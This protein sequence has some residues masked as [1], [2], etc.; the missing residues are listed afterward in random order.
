M[1]IKNKF[2]IERIIET[3]PV[4]DSVSIYKEDIY[5]DG[6]LIQSTQ[7][8]ADNNCF[9]IKNIEP[10]KCKNFYFVI[11]ST[12]LNKWNLEFTYIEDYIISNP[13]ENYDPEKH[14]VIRY[15]P[16]SEEVFNLKNQT[17]PKFI[18]F[19]YISGGID[20]ENYNLDL[21]KDFLSK[22]P[23]KFINIE[24]K[25]IPYYNSTETCTESL[26]FTF[27][28]NFDEYNE[29][30]EYTKMNGYEIAANYFKNVLNFK[31][32]KNNKKEG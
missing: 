28:P 9:N 24:K 30:I 29:Y 11:D 25:N 17:Y 15:D 31:I 12:F 8:V 6:T 23:D 5:Q 10:I 20:N 4:S 27:I 3:I 13:F 1:T 22:Y 26:D 16:L 2:Q 7:G 32:F 19:N 18:Q 21:L 14:S